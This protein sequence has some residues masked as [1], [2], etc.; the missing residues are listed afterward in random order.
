MQQDEFEQTLTD[1]GIEIVRQYAT[2]HRHTVTIDN[3]DG[4]IEIVRLS[5]CGLKGIARIFID[6]A[7][8]EPIVV[9]ALLC[10]DGRKIVDLGESVIFSTIPNNEQLFQAVETQLARVANARLER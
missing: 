10:M 9:L 6:S 3:G 4:I 2:K 1:I 7:Q 5:A 8:N